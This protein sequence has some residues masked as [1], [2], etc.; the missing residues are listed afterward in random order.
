LLAL[1]EEKES[2]WIAWP[3]GVPAGAIDGLAGFRND[4]KRRERVFGNLFGQ[5][6]IAMI[7]ELW[8]G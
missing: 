6:A 1:G 8:I 4:L 2:V 7:A 5:F 3:L